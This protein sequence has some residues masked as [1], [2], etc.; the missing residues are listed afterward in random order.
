MSSSVPVYAS[1]GVADG[2]VRASW[3][4]KTAEGLRARGYGVSFT[5]HEGLHHELGDRQARESKNK[6]ERATTV[7]VVLSCPLVQVVVG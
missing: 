5:E 4:R 2:M 6:N 7:Q 1:H 3:G